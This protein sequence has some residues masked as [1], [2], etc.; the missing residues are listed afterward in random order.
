MNYSI[1]LIDPEA[2]RLREVASLLEK[3][4]MNMLTAKNVAEAEQHLLND[5]SIQAVL[6]SWKVP[7]SDSDKSYVVGEELFKHI[8]K[9]RFEVD[10]FLLTNKTAGEIYT[11]GGLLSGYFYRGDNDYEEIASK[12]HSVVYN[13][14]IRA[15][16]FD[17]LVD[18][19]NTARLS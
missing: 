14:K 17:A 6:T 3:Q 1:L 16:F 11:T 8:S 2:K 13:G 5:G 7:I 18:Y 12:I 19:S 10:I 9:I 15:P 4:G